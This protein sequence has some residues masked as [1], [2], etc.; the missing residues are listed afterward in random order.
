MLPEEGMRLGRYH[1]MAE[2]LVKTGYNVTLFISNFS[3]RTKKKAL[4]FNSST[5]VNG[6]EYKMIKS[7]TYDSHISLDRIFYEKKFIKNLIASIK[8]ES[9]PDLIVIRDPAIFISN[10]LISFVK[11]NEIKYIVDIIDLWP[12]LFEMVLPKYLQKYSKLIFSSFYK[13]R[14][15][16]LA[17][18]SAYTAVAPDYL[19]I[20]TDINSMKLSQ[21]IFWGCDYQKIKSLSSKKGVEILNKFSLKKEKGDFWLIYSG[22]LGDNYDIKSI[23]YVGEQL[24]SYCNVKFIIAGSGPLSSWIQNFIRQKKPTNI[25][26]IG[27]IKSDELFALFG[28]CD[29]GL[30]TYTKKSTV[31]MPIKCYDYFASGLPVINCLGRNLGKIV[32]EHNLG[33]NY[34]AEDISSMKEV[35][36]KS[37]LDKIG[38]LDKKNNVLKIASQFEQSTQYQLLGDLVNKTLAG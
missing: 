16:L 24:S 9:K 12:E 38:Y 4:R 31:S 26:F 32:S 14:T 17:G 13:R 18:A 22:T 11:K 28:F 8:D 27:E 36:L 2:V 15:K 37:Y 29:I 1:Q 6:I 23:F 5:F 19:K 3:H 21:V 30:T 33:Y 7:S 35:I 10:T 34:L 20:A 25:F